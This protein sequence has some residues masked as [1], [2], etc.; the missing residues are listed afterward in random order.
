VEDGHYP[1]KPFTDE[2]N[3]FLKANVK[4]KSYTKLAEMFN[5]QFGTNYKRLAISKRCRRLGLSN[6]DNRH[7]YTA[8]EIDFLR[9][10][11]AGTGYEELA[12]MFNKRFNATISANRIGELCRRHDMPNKL[13]CRYTEGHT[14]NLGRKFDFA[15]PDGSE[16]INA[17]GYVLIKKN[18]KWRTKHTVIWEEAHGSIP[19]GYHVIFGDGDK[20]NF[21]LDNLYCISHSQAAMRIAR[22]LRSSNPELAQLG[23]AIAGL[24]TQI[25]KRK[26]N[27]P[28]SRK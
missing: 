14:T 16:M 25:N 13:D 9:E 1:R 2:Q 7:P 23:I 8:E 15:Q 20:H 17:L 26:K 19:E 10:N 28:N 3:E 27:K 4:G 21:N 24:Y 12:E 5:Q 6:G 22:G 18:G 11:V